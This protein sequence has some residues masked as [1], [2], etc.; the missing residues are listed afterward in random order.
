[1][2]QSV[3]NSDLL[4][5]GPRL[6]E[7]LLPGNYFSSCSRGGDVALPRNNN[8]SVEIQKAN[9]SM[10]V[11][12]VYIPR[13]ALSWHSRTC[14]SPHFPQLRIIPEASNISRSS[15]TVY[16]AWT[17]LVGISRDADV[18]LALLFVRFSAMSC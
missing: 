3:R 11:A 18:L 9:M 4:A 2:E 14:F 6:L 10:K 13:S 17:P 5:G 1:M 7:D 16:V 12:C 8:S 15:S